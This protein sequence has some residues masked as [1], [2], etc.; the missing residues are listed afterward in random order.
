MGFNSVKQHTVRW[1]KI[2]AH[3]TGLVVG[4]GLQRRDRRTTLS[5]ARQYGS[6]IDAR[7]ASAR[8][9]SQIPACMQCVEG[10]PDR[11]WHGACLCS[12]H[13]NKPTNTGPHHA[14]SHSTADRGG[15]RCLTGVA[16]WQPCCGRW[17]DPV[18]RRDSQ[19]SSR[20]HQVTSLGHCDSHWQAGHRNGRPSRFPLA[21]RTLCRHLDGNTAVG[22]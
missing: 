21:P 6:L 18:T 5:S 19:R 13:V 16:N 12:G 8:L 4:K 15:R 10:I 20:P 14:C 1:Q 11:A 9:T 2:A 17:R 7:D 22:K 3:R